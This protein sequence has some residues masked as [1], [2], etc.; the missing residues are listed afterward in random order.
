MK[1]IIKSFVSFSRTEKWGIIGLL[2][3]AVILIAIRLSLHLWVHPPDNNAEQQL[4]HKWDSFKKVNDLI[5]V[6]DMVYDSVG[7]EGDTDIF[8]DNKVAVKIN[9]NTADS[10]TLVSLNGIG[11]VTAQR[12]ISYR[13]AKGKFYSVNEL[14][15]VYH[16]SYNTMQQLK[17]QLVVK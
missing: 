16:F 3:L 11:P 8:P 17:K 1:R 12:I 5:E 9:L 15:E 4:L 10:A 2:L 6:D 7:K 13:K 14:K